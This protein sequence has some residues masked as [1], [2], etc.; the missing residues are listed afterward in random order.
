MLAIIRQ[1][2]LHLILVLIGVSILT[3][4]ISHLIPTDVARLI[5]GNQA[6]DKVV[7]AI[8]AE[9]RLDEPV[10]VQYWHYI[11]QLA[12]GD[13]GKSIR[14]GHPVIEDIGKF[15][16]AT[17]ELVIVSLF[18][19]VIMGLPLAVISA[20]YKNSW[21]DHLIRTISIGGIS[22]PS[23]W[24]A[25]LLI[26]LFYGVLDIFPPSGRIDPA[27]ADIGS[28]TGFMLLD[29]ILAANMSAFFNALAHLALPAF[30]MGFVTMGYVVRIVR[31]SMLEVLQEDYVRTARA[32][33][34]SELRVTVNHALRNALIP[35]VTSLGLALGD[36]LAGSVVTESIFSWP[37]MGSYILQAAL[38]L[39]FPA[40]M[41]FTLLVSIIYVFA[42][43]LVDLMYIL[44][45]PRVAADSS[46]A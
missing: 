26:Y 36:L 30:T 6:S 31:A 4:T 21:A 32:G 34:L 20:V 1:R 44:L 13:L 42:N 35:F 17:F 11:K 22:T 14:T 28:V 16:P 18:I 38:A 8:R 25:L 29:S 43:L 39:D 37:G 45:D 19:A 27:Y 7:E 40:I 15:F 33:G 5:A 24:L 23:F 2:L 9:L 41:G 10:Y 3:F 12:R 46:K